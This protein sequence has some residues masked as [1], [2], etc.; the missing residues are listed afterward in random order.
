MLGIVTLLSACSAPAQVPYVEAIYDEETGRL[1]ELA[2]DG[3]GNGRV[4]GW[5][6]MD[7]TEVLRIELDRDENGLVERWEYYGPGQRIEKV[8]ISRAANGKPDA[9]FYQGADGAL[10]KLELAAGGD[11]RITRTEFYEEGQLARSTEDTN[12]DGAVDKWETFHDGAVTSVAFDLEKAGR[13][14]QRLLYARDG[15]LLR[16]DTGVALEKAPF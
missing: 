5:S 3:N 2:Y 14:T 10:V 13:P 9:W 15:S 1:R 6:Y 11:G 12:G 8:G 4:D 16:V 7:G